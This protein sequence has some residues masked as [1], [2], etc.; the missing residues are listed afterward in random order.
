MTCPKCGTVNPAGMRY[1]GMCGRALEAAASG[2]E[3]RRVSIVFVDLAAF[4]DLT[5]DQDPE[6]LRDLADKVLTVVAGVIEEFDGYV[7]AFRG[8]GLIALFGAPHSHPDDPERAVRAAASSLRAIERIGSARGIALRGRAGV[9]TGVVIAGAIGS[10]R[11]RDYTVMGSA[12]N[13]AARLEAAAQPGEVWVG[14]ETFR[15]VRHRLA[16]ETTE[17]LTIDGFPDVTRA[18][19]LVTRDDARSIDPYAAL[20]FVGRDAEVRA[21]R[22]LRDQVADAGRARE[23]WIAGDA[24]SGK[25]RLIREAFRSASDAPP[26]AGGDTVLW[27]RVPVDG[28]F[29]WPQ[30]ASVVFGVD[31]AAQSPSSRQRIERDLTRLLP[32]EPRWW[33]SVLASLELVER[34]PWRRLDR[35]ETDREALAWSDLLSARARASDGVWI[36]VVDDDPHHVG[37]DSFLSMVRRATAPILVV[38]SSRARHVPANAERIRIAPLSPDESLELV[39]QLIEPPME[40][41]AR[42][43]ASQVGGVP[44]HLIELGRA[45]SLQED[46]AVSLSLAGLLQARL[47]RLDASARTLLAH[48][49]LTGERVWDGLLRELSPGRRGRAIE[50]LVSDKL[51]AP[52]PGSSLPGQREYR[53]Q[54]ELL[55]RAVMRMVPFSERPPVHVRI[56]SWLEANAPLAFSEAIGEQFARGGAPE[57]AYAHWMA[58]AEFHQQ[59]DEPDRTDGLFTRVL[60][61]A[62]SAELR[63][64]AALAWAQSAV[65]RGDAGAAQ[66]AL[67]RSTPFIRDCD[68]ESCERLRSVRDRLA[69]DVLRLAAAT[70]AGGSA[71]GP[72]T[73]AEASP[74]DA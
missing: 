42:T 48:A 73:D 49:S 61:L 23:I 16:F 43:L 30:L 27:L 36:L 7:D 60:D 4:S 17:E 40:R 10:G 51:L 22:A 13:L 28:E 53:F 72:E 9:N 41:A 69:E 31:E 55:R 50:S 34:Q 6:E 58:A 25:S 8:D 11:V 45:L 21:L 26:M 52:E 14:P 46:S 68:E 62:V 63:A 54:S 47:D 5:R 32:G 74:P 2:R 15:A 24:G 39:R 71:T 33:R 59:Q 64:Q 65:G 38:R 12:V 19:R 29:P 1:C 70:A 18:F 44:A 37:L 20:S 57:A 67:D 66:A 56:A 3:R 35:R